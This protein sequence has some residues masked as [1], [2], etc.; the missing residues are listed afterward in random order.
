MATSVRN[1]YTITYK[2]TNTKMDG[3]Y[4]KIK[5]ELVKPG[6][7]TPLIVKD[8]KDKPLKYQLVYR[9]GYTAKHQVE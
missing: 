2:P 3:T 6:S 1:Q 7:E 9:E 4:R 5:V 8:Q